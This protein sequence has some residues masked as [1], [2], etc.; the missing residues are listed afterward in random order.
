MIKE[1]VV[2]EEGKFYRHSVKQQT[3][4]KVTG[5]DP[6][7]F[8]LIEY[9]DEREGKL[10]PEAQGWKEIPETEWDKKVTESQK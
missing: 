9:P 10:I 1:E 2:F 4:V 7:G 3:Y 8:I 5:T 6:L